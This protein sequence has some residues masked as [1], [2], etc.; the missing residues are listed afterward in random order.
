MPFWYVSS[1]STV[2]IEAAPPIER[3]GRVCREERER[4]GRGRGEEDRVQTFNAQ[5][6]PTT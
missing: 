1:S 2:N 4:E 3:G 6:T 5:H